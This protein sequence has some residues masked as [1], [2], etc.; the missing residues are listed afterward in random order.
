MVK[1]HH[2]ITSHVSIMDS[3]WSVCTPLFQSTFFQN[4][5]QWI[6]SFLFHGS[7]YENTAFSKKI[8]LSNIN[9]MKNTQYASFFIIVILQFEIKIFDI[10][11]TYYHLIC[12]CIGY[13]LTAQYLLGL[14]SDLW[15][16]YIASVR[17]NNSFSDDPPIYPLSDTFYWLPI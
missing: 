11:V 5:S 17:D 9:C 1:L 15:L 14:I 7:H 6:F 13:F 16:N 10:A 12:S 8:M 3:E 2:A 4:T